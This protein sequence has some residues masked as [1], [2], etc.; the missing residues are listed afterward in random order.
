MYIF[1]YKIKVFSVNRQCNLAKA[2]V[3]ETI[4]SILICFD[5]IGY[6][7]TKDGDA[8][9]EF[10]HLMGILVWVC[11]CGNSFMGE[12]TFCFNTYLKSVN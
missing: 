3:Q 6:P 7:V 1:N 10:H 5:L 11:P 9:I 12:I 8:H 4:Y 2:N